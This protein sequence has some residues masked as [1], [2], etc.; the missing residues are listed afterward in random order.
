MLQEL[1]QY[2]LF[3]LSGQFIKEIKGEAETSNVQGL[4]GRRGQ[5]AQSDKSTKTRTC[6]V[7]ANMPAVHC[8][9]VLGVRPGYDTQQS[10]TRNR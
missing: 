10:Q 2:S 5:T 1:S 4:E 9:C 3:V 8:H 7:H 6:I